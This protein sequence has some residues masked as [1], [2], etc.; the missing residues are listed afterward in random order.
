MAQRLIE[1]A[2]SLNERPHLRRTMRGIVA[3]AA[4]RDWQLRPMAYF[5]T[6]PLW[7][8]R[9]DPLRPADGRISGATTKQALK[10]ILQRPEPVVVVNCSPPLPDH[11][12]SVRI[13]YSAAAR[14]AVEHLIRQQGIHQL[15]WFGST[16]PER[17]EHRDYQQAVEAACAQAGIDPIVYNRLPRNRDWADLIPQVRQWADWLR[18][19]PAGTGIICA[20]DEFAGRIYLASERAGRPIGPEISVIG[21][22]NEALFCESLEPSLSSIRVDYFQLGWEAARLLDARLEDPELRP[23]TTWINSS[24]LVIRESSFLSAIKAKALHHVLGT[25]RLRFGDQLTVDKL[26]AA[27][28][29]DRHSLNRLF[30]ET[31]GSSVHAELLRVRLHNAQRLLRSTD[32][33]IAEIALVC[34]FADQAHFSRSFK[35]QAGLTPSQFRKNRK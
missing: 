11:V 25:I 20:D 3:Y 2:F 14:L 31:V 19:L 12:P 18:S 30:R 1:I 24:S 35:Q 29:L 16:H 10:R 17:L 21:L 8:F 6:T 4:Q 28:G 26:A 23:P 13:D 9:N 5:T 33:P 22:G 32:K 27:A 7:A 34:G 15:A